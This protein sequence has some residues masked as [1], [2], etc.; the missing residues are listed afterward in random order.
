[1]FLNIKGTKEYEMSVCLYVEAICLLMKVNDISILV[2]HYLRRF[3][4][5]TLSELSCLFS[6]PLE[7]KPES[8]VPPPL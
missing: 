1:M 8:A 2:E 5:K 6:N 3:E 7:P 4:P